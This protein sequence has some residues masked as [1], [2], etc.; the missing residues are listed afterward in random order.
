[1]GRYIKVN[2]GNNTRTYVYKQVD[3]FL[4]EGMM[5]WVPT[6]NGLKKGMIVWEGKIKDV[7]LP[8]PQNKILDIKSRCYSSVSE[9]ELTRY[10]GVLIEWYKEGTMSKEQLAFVFEGLVSNNDLDFENNFELR[11]FFENEL[12]DICLIY[13]DEPGN[14][15]EKEVEFWKS[16]REWE[17]KIKYG[18]FYKDRNKQKLNLLFPLKESEVED[19]DEYARVELEVERR[20]KNEIGEGGYM[21]YC[22]RYWSVKKRILAEYGIDWKTPQE[23]NPEVNFD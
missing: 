3:N 7:E 22:H 11:D 10:F 15:S 18:Y 12:P 5:V 17:Y 16:M 13:V 8:V 21:G 20:I 6:K 19:T 23:L 1:M 2:F 9:K 4:S 14:E